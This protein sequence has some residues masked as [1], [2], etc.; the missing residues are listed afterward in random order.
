MSGGRRLRVVLA[1]RHYCEECDNRVFPG[2]S[3]ERFT[4]VALGVNGERIL[5]P[6]VNS[7]LQR[8]GVV[9]RKA[10]CFICKKIV[11]TYRETVRDVEQRYFNRRGVTIRYKKGGGAILSL[12]RRSA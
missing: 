9:E 10:W 3:L 7:R 1:N 4:E 12:R 2:D 8:Q 11:D 5:L 6:S